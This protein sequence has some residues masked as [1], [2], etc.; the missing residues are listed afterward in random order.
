V[1]EFGDPITVSAELIAKFKEGGTEKREACS[2]LLD[3]IYNALKTVTIN[4]GSYETLMV[5]FKL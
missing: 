3:T 1:I 4:A 5:N 2:T